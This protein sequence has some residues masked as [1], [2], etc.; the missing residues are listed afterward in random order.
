MPFTARA[1]VSKL[2]PPRKMRRKTVGFPGWL[3]A[4]SGFV[5]LL[6]PAAAASGPWHDT[7]DIAATAESFLIGKLGRSGDDTS[8]R[9]GMLDGRLKLAACDTALEGFLRPGAKIGPKT[10]VGV[11][12]PGSKP[13]K[14]Y[15]PVEVVVRTRVW[16][17]GQPLP[18][19]HL[20]T[21]A[22]LRED[23]RD[24]ARM[25][26]GYVSDPQRLI[27]QRLR[28]SVLAG[29]VLTLKLIEADT[30]VERGQSVTLAV[31][32]GGI[33]IRMSGKALMDGALNERIRVE[34]L[35]SGR[36]VEGIVRS[37]EIV[38]I[39]VPGTADSAVFH[40]KVSAPGADTLS[41]NNDR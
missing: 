12:C 24:V 5:S 1:F 23:V 27:G 36:V 35:N 30:I 7:S 41:S 17:A 2:T 4:V 8:V 10:I 39:L 9:A 6:H 37:R 33:S 18:R 40:P 15:V 16:V 11:R 20:L 3:V 26:A 34:N 31:M 22:D 25:R 29:R 19:G 21:R 28:T 38:E 13:W 32:S 14:M